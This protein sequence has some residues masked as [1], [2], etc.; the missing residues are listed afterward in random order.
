MI[1]E[2]NR[3]ISNIDFIQRVFQILNIP[4]PSLVEGIIDNLST[5]VSD[6]NL[7]RPLFN[8]IE[9][10]KSSLR[11]SIPFHLERK[12]LDHMQK[13]EI[14]EVLINDFSFSKGNMY[15]FSHLIKPFLSSEQIDKI[16]NIFR[17]HLGQIKNHNGSNI[18]E[19]DINLTF[20][21]LEELLR[22]RIFNTDQTSVIF[23][24]LI[25]E[26]S[27]IMNILN[28][29]DYHTRSYH[30]ELIN[31]LLNSQLKLNNDLTEINL[32]LDQ[33]ITILL[34]SKDENTIVYKNVFLQQILL[35]LDNLNRLYL[36]EENVNNV[37]KEIL[38]RFGQVLRTLLANP[39]FS[40]EQREQFSKL[41]TENEN[42]LSTYNKPNETS[43]FQQTSQNSEQED[44]DD[45]GLSILFGNITLNQNN[46]SE[47]SSSQTNNVAPSL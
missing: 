34:P 46:S 33:L 16:F 10:L 26:Y 32:I 13:Q 21:D 2:Y 36:C 45:M 8:Y 18:L 23:K 17:N 22:N 6:D 15:H 5:N 37:N 14:T 41:L 44:N 28:T 19:K 42:K 47:Q 39:S 12:D 30:W 7:I 38:G 9:Y 43:S 31:V 29:T 4:Y 20:C 40:P 35:V 24:I 3:F 11:C 25:A 1:S 27:N